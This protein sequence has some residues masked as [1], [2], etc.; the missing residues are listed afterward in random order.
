MSRHGFT[1]VDR[2]IRALASL[3]LILS[4]IGNQ[5]LVP[6]AQAAAD[7]LLQPATE[8]P[9]PTATATSTSTE[10]ATASPAD[11]ATPT[12]VESAT[13]ELK[14][15]ETPAKPS[16]EPSGTESSTP[17]APTATP[18]GTATASPTGTASA[19]PTETQQPPATA[20]TRAT[21]APTATLSATEPVTGTLSDVIDPAKGAIVGSSKD[22]ITITVPTD[23]FTVSVQISIAVVDL[24][25]TKLGAPDGIAIHRALDLIARVADK[26]VPTPTPE[27]K[28]AAES[29][30]GSA[31]DA[32]TD[33]TIDK[34]AKPLTV[35][36]DITDLVTNDPTHTGAI[37][38]GYWDEKEG[39]WR[40][41]SFHRETR[42]DGTIQAVFETDHF[43]VYGSGFGTLAGWVPTFVQPNVAQFSGAMT[44]AYPLAL[45]EGRAGLTPS[46]ALS[47]NSRAVDGITSWTQGSEVGLGWTLGTP[48]ISRSFKREGDGDSPPVATCYEPGTESD[49]FTLQVGGA[50]YV[51]LKSNE[52][53]VPQGYVRYVTQ[54]RSGIYVE[55][56]NAV[57]NAQVGDPTAIPNQTGEYWIVRMPDGTVYRFGWFANAELLVRRGNN[58]NTTDARASNYV[59]D[60]SPSDALALMWMVDTVWDSHTWNPGWWAGAHNFIRYDY[61]SDPAC[62]HTLYPI[63][64]DGNGNESGGHPYFENAIYLQDIVYNF[65][66]TNGEG[67][68]TRVD[69]ELVKRRTSNLGSGTTDA[70]AATRC[71]TGDFGGGLTADLLHQSRYVASLTV[72]SESVLLHKYVLGYSGQTN[73]AL[74]NPQHLDEATRLL[75]SITEYGRG[76]VGPLPATSFGYTTPLDNKEKSG[77]GDIGNTGFAYARV[78]EVNN[79]YGGRMTYDYAS[80]INRPGTDDEKY[81]RVTWQDVYDGIHVGF[82]RTTYEY[83]GVCFR[84][85]PLTS[86]QINQLPAGMGAAGGNGGCPNI[87]PNKNTEEL[88]GYQTVTT[89]SYDY[90]TWASGAP[91]LLATVK[92]TY[93]TQEWGSQLAGRE[94]KVEVMNAAASEVYSISE[95]TYYDA[96]TDSASHTYPA[97]VQIQRNSRCTGS[98]SNPSCAGN[99]TEYS[100]YDSFENPRVI[101]E[102]ASPTGPTVYRTTE[103]SY[104]ISNL[105]TDTS[106]PVS[107]GAGQRVY[108]VSK[109]SVTITWL[110]DGPDYP[111]QN[112]KLIARTIYEYD[113]PD[114]PTSQPLKGDLAVVTVHKW[115][116]AAGPG[117]ATIATQTRTWYN[118]YGLPTQILD[119]AGKGVQYGYDGTYLNLASITNT[120]AGLSVSAYIDPVTRRV[121]RITDET[122][123]KTCYAY[124]PFS[125]LFAVYTPGDFSLVEYPGTSCPA[126]DTAFT[127]AR[128]PSVYY[129]YYDTNWN[130]F[131][132]GYNNGIGTGVQPYVGKVSKPAT[133]ASAIAVR[134]LYD[135][136]GRLVQTHTSH[137]ALINGVNS[138]TLVSTGYDGLGRQTYQTVPYTIPAVGGGI[139]PY[140][141]TNL[142]AAART[143]TTYNAAGWVLTSVGPNG[144]QSEHHYGAVDEYGQ[145]LFYDD[146]VD[147]DRHRVQTRI[148]GFGRLTSVYELRGDCNGWTYTCT[149]PYITPWAIYAWTRYSYDVRDLLKTVTDQ[150]N[151]VTALSYNPAGQ[152]SAIDDPD[153]GTWSYDYDNSGNLSHQTDNRG[154][155]TTLLYDNANRLTDKQYASG[156][157]AATA[158]VNYTYVPQGSYGAG[159]R[160]VMTDGSGTTTLT[161]NQRG[162]LQQE[163]RVINSVTYITGFTYD[164]LDRLQDVTYPNGEVVR[165]SYDSARAGNVTGIQSLEPA[166]S[167]GNYASGLTFDAEGR[168]THI[169]YGNNAYTNYT[170][171]PW[172][173][174]G[175]QGGGLQYLRTKFGPTDLQVFDYYYDPVGNLTTLYDALNGPQ[176]LTFTYDHLN[177]LYSARSSGGDAVNH[178]YR[179]DE[180]GNLTNGE[181]GAMTYGPDN[182]G[183]SR[184]WNGQPHA[185]KTANGLTQAYDCNGNQ[186]T[187][188]EGTNTYTQ[189]WDQENRLL[190]VEQTAPITGTTTFQYDGDGQR[191]MQTL[192]N[193][194]QIVYVNRY[195]E[196]EC[197]VPA[198]P[199]LTGPATPIPPGTAAITWEAVPSATGYTLRI[200]DQSNGIGTDAEVGV[201]GTSYSYAFQSSRTYGLT[202]RADKS[203]N[204]LHSP[205]S[206]TR[207]VTVSANTG[208]T[209]TAVAQ[210]AI[211][212]T[213]AAQT[214][215]AQTAEAQTAAAQ[216]S[217]AQTSVAQTLTAQVPTATLTPTATRTATAVS[218]GCPG[219]SLVVNGCFETGN[220]TG[221]EVYGG[222]P[223]ITTGARYSEAYGLN[224]PDNSAVRQVF[225]TVAGQ[226]YQVSARLRINSQSGSDWGGYSVGITSYDWNN[227]GQSAFYTTANSPLGTWTL[228]TFSFTA[229]S[230]ES[231]IEVD[232]F[233]GQNLILTAD[234]DEISVVPAGGPTHTPTHTATRTATAT[235]SFSRHRAQGI[236]HPSCT[237]EGVC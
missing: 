9:T 20:T 174:G 74:G 233:A 118:A 80:T 124:D 27:G 167:P 84:Q 143:T 164:A 206:A 76:N 17:T 4:L 199:V 38:V 205:W 153:M 49:V 25:S 95:T 11:R 132:T 177:R 172:N 142:A 203:C 54:E 184:D 207:T 3:G 36:M 229:T 162:L 61:V 170:Y 46:L 100:L 19:T 180:V 13:L 99:R 176:T 6:F 15:T 140:S 88:A 1:L 21:A 44:Y 152:K 141:T 102:Y 64:I 237:A 103:I 166:Y 163:Q 42:K 217:V 66:L 119:Y 215:A 81:Y 133:L 71:G 106:L 65:G 22:G 75:S 216:T 145:L 158:N 73:H 200:D 204:N 121:R 183:C 136:W 146:V 31:L 39:Q 224:F 161:Y 135:G 209:Q 144:A 105:V 77:N 87:W 115:T 139:N 43:T 168:M 37:W 108:I 159:Q 223:S 34:F 53:P 32:S 63:T 109:P 232:E 122:G 173:A 211:A 120:S 96:T 193:G 78:N 85:G 57:L 23:A 196:V 156:G 114:A 234:W 72:S 235:V 182:P 219:N 194:G 227:L 33:Q 181:A 24:A 92:S 213:A 104:A 150:L 82:A 210:T 230:T 228:I 51:L 8:T 28:P 47:Y 192:P 226:T 157:C 79:G 212:Q 220:L 26:A 16:P 14:Q 147:P 155:V 90:G 160:Q 60:N 191:V 214:A 195:Y 86:D 41:V 101:K 187:R 18:T 50:G 48:M 171:Y 40:G 189:T 186:T 236:F 112:T 222:S 185:V 12:A 69:I 225:T 127:T 128:D 30:E 165:Q 10:T 202:V 89:R 5:G 55:R 83:H 56:H 126:D 68:H 123:Q 58:C 62:H 179:Y 91:T 218:S 93:Y 188:R 138:D 198:I 59:G 45:P 97:R 201:T 131:I 110:G 29:S 117:S 151:H 67:Y 111:N 98:P 130:S 190:S 154:C 129:K 107:W 35:E 148:D 178:D 231:R 197:L 149:A 208:A 221:W 2:L 113:S 94:Q 125:R 137:D 175:Q 52:T 7:A 116:T 134:Q 70:F 169:N